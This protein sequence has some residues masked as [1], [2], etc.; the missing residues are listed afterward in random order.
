MSESQPAAL[1]DLLWRT[2][3]DVIGVPAT[4]TV[5]RRCVQRLTGRWPNLAQLTVSKAQYSFRYST[6]PDWAEAS[7]Q[8]TAELRDLVREI[9]RL[10]Q[11][12]TGS[13]VVYRLEQLPELHECHLLNDGSRP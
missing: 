11:E 3:A 4:A 13:I 5:V 10:L 7:E 1:F 2:V 6:P 8:S 12:L 9:C